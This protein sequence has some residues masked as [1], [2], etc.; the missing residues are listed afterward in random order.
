MNP[1]TGKPYYGSFPFIT[2]RDMVNAHLLLADHLG[3]GSVR[4]RDRQLDRRGFRAL[5]MALG[6]ARFRERSL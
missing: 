3:V 4:G 5:E 1:A 6:E 2:V